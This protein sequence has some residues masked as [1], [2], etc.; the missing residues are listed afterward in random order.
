MPCSNPTDESPGVITSPSQ[1]GRCR[2]TDLKSANAVNRDRPVSRQL[3]DPARECSGSMHR[4]TREH[5]VASGQV[6]GLTEIEKYRTAIIVNLER[7]LQLL[8]RYPH[9]FL[10][11]RTEGK[12]KLVFSRSSPI[13]RRYR[14]PIR[15]QF[16][17][18]IT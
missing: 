8:G 9:L 14:A 17:F 18:A 1:L 10:R 15:C 3:L 13:A 16:R 7:G 12:K 6:P 11:R 2:A 5:I 4:G